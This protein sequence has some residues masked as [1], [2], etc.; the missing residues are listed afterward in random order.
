MRFHRLTFLAALVLVLTGCYDEL[1]HGLEERAA[2]EIVVALE[3]TGVD[4]QKVRDEQDAERWMVRVPSGAHVEAMHA[5]E[6]RGLPRP[7]I[8]GFGTFY[9]SEGLVPTSSEEQVLLQYATSQELRRSL[10]AIDGIVDA[11]VNLVLP[12]SRRRL[13]SQPN[14]PAR[15]S[16]VVKYQAA[17]KPPVTVENV[18]EV[19]AGGVDGLDADSVH[20]LLTPSHET[21]K[22]LEEPRLVQVGPLSVPAAAG[23]LAR[24]VFGL[25]TS[26]ILGLAGAIVVLLVR[27]RRK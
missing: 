14:R 26:L 25:M 27:R 6:S 20:V 4:A 7:E 18:R 1:Y 16:V 19:V 9:P 17:E 24:V 3:Q 11:H 8:S 22:P 2:N 10:L 23:N 12:D 5:L 15:A 21:M 13:G